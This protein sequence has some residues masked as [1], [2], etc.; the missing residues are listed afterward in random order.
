MLTPEEIEQELELIASEAKAV[1]RR[2]TVV[3]KMVARLREATATDSPQEGTRHERNPDDYAE[4]P[5][6][7]DLEERLSY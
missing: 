1:R 7:Y 6:P 5:E 2:A 4:R 3:V